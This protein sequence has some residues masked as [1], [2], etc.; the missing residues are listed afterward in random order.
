MRC[1]ISDTVRNVKCTARMI[2]ININLGQRS[3]GPKGRAGQA[4][5]VGG[6]L[7]SILDYL[8]CHLL[9][10]RAATAV[11]YGCCI[12]ATVIPRLHMHF[13]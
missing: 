1:R 7:K 6:S 4:R 5:R 2:Y 10:T 13:L 12:R 11:R 3:S 9:C 8:I